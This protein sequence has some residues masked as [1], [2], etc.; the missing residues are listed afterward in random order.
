VGNSQYNRNNLTLPFFNFKL[1]EKVMPTE[2][3]VK[4]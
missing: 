1:D 3:Q 2:K 4:N